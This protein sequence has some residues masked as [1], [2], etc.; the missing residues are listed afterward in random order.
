MDALNYNLFPKIKRFLKQ[1]WLATFKTYFITIRFHQNDQS[2]KSMGGFQNFFEIGS[3]PMLWVR[4]PLTTLFLWTISWKD[5]FFKFFT[6]N[7]NFFG[8][9]EN[10]ENDLF[11]L[12]MNWFISSYKMLSWRFVTSYQ[13][14][15]YLSNRG[16]FS[17]MELS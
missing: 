16:L 7:L 10:H 12:S 3:K 4:F 9:L 17:R 8:I 14:L 15:V 2:K 1:T 11:G 5:Q 13:P 6:M